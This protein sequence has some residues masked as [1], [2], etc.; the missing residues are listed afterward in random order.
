[1]NQTNLVTA[2]PLPAS[3]TLE[4]L[5]RQSLEEQRA[6]FEYLKRTLN[7]PVN[8]ESPSPD[9][10]D[11][12]AVRIAIPGQPIP[13]M[14]VEKVAQMFKQ[15]ESFDPN[16][17]RETLEYLQQALNEERA[18]HGARPLLA[19]ETGATCAL[20]GPPIHPNAYGAPLPAFDSAGAI[21]FLESLYE[22]ETE[23]QTATFEYLKQAL[24][25]TRAANGE[26][27][28]FLDE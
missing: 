5:R 16:E 17:Q 24:N 4:W 25:E 11:E 3:A 8:G 21:A 15:L 12:A 2:E 7:E 18:A 22:G 27:L 26:R 13:V 19:E 23:E 9:T 1:M 28:L 6:T 14:D 10:R 20:T